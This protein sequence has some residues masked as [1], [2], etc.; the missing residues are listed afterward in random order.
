MTVQIKDKAGTVLHTLDTDTLYGAELQGLSLAGADFRGK[1]LPHANFEG[2][3]LTGADFEDANIGNANLKTATIT[4]AN[5]VRTNYK[6]AD[7]TDAVLTPG[8][9]LKKKTPLISKQEVFNGWVEL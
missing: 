7:F 1:R 9:T 4:N 5:F 2:T 3:D 8:Y 6:G